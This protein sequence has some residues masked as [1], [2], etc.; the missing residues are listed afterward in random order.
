VAKT[1]EQVDRGAVGRQHRDA[2]AGVV[3]GG[4]REVIVK[5]SGLAPGQRYTLNVSAAVDQA[6]TPNTMDSTNIVFR[7]PF[8][9][10][11]L[12]DWDYYYYG[13]STLGNPITDLTSSQNY[14]D[15]PWTNWG[16]TTFNSQEI[17]VSDLNGKWGD[18]GDHHGAVVS[19]WIT[20]TVAGNYTFFLHSDDASELYV[21]TSSDP[22]S[23]QLIAYDLTC[24]HNFTEKYG[25][26]T[27]TSD[28]IPW[29]RTRRTSSSHGTRKAAAAEIM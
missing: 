23:A 24:C 8:L 20:P 11:G 29:R 4:W 9:S 5:T 27:F 18:L 16:L 15:V 25:A 1:G 17:T 19:G 13:T 28:P 22:A 14:P 10:K 7:A 2:G 21:G 3:G 6:A 26:N 12:A